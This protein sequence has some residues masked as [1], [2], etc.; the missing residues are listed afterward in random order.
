MRRIFL[1]AA[2]LLLAFAAPA[3]ADH[4]YVGRVPWSQA[5]VEALRG[6]ELAAVAK[7]VNVTRPATFLTNQIMPNQ[8]VGFAWARSDGGT[9]PGISVDEQRQPAGAVVRARDFL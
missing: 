2:F 7:F 5:N 4:V 6:A 9:Q 8:V 1:P 3:F